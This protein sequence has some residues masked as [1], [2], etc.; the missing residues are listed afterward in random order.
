MINI[1]PIFVGAVLLVFSIIDWK[2]R[3]LPSIL[4]TAMLFTVAFLFPANL[5]FGVLGFIIAYLLYEAD[6]FEG[7][8]DIKIMTMISFMMF[9]REWFALFIVLT[10]IFGTA[11]KT[12][13]KWRTKQEKGAFLPVFL[14][15]YIAMYIL[16]GI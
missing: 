12:I 11:W 6:Y 15:V 3:K 4:T 1:I 9:S 13:L 10:L 14:F 5:W 2:V 8:A 16:G 7:V